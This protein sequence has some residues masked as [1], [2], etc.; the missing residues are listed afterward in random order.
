MSTTYDYMFK[1]LILGDSGVGKS[2]FLLRFIDESFSLSHI[3]TIGID[4]KT[5]FITLSNSRIKLQIWD[6]AGQE[7]FKTITKTYY[8]GA[9]GIIVAYDCTRPESFENVRSWVEIIKL[10][11][12]EHIALVLIGNKSDIAESK[13]P[14]AQGAALANEL[15]VQF[16]ATSAKNNICV[17][18]TIMYLA[19]EIYERKL[20]EVIGNAANVRVGKAGKKKKTCC[21]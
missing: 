3:P 5:K 13:V 11:A 16:F 20:Y 2:C 9:M 4:F 19:N 21:R 14:E 18:E 7:R 6:T 15:G 1:I 17:N 10:H 8:A 12:S